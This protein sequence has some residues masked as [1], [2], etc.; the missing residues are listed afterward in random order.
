MWHFCH[1][2]LSQASMQ[3][4]S[5]WHQH[6]PCLESSHFA[7][8]RRLFICQLKIKL[9][10]TYRTRV[11]SRVNSMTLLCLCLKQTSWTGSMWQSMFWSWLLAVDKPEGN[12]EESIQT[13]L[14]WHKKWAIRNLLEFHICRLVLGC[15]D[16]LQKHRLVCHQ[17]E[18]ST[19]E[20][21][22]SEH[23]AFAVMKAYC[24]HNCVVEV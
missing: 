9:C 2:L 12:S 5:N 21:N 8:R 16:A 3:L 23:S 15:T 4:T 18:R 10:K 1:W 24:S 14:N 11:Y 7:T 22:W 6:L 13:E 17:W 20:L 19:K